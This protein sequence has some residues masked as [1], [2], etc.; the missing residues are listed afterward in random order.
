MCSKRSARSASLARAAVL[1][2]LLVIPGLAQLIDCIVAEVN[3]Q[4]IT[5]T[6]L[7]I[8]RAF[9]ITLAGSGE[10]SPIPV[11]QILEGA[12]DQKVV[13]GLVRENISVSR[14]E[15]N[16]LLDELK[17]NFDPGE[18]ASKL[19]AFG[20][21]PADLEPYLRE[22][23]MYEKIIG[24][25]FGQSIDVNLQEIERYYDDVYAPAQ[26]AQGK[27]PEPMVQVLNNI[28]ARIRREKTEQQVASWVHS[29]RGQADIRVNSDCLQKIE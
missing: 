18:W 7:R 5:L 28:E 8:L 11:R 17:Q 19:D 29:L 16:G 6:D 4:I 12:I 13:I 2:F 10:E 24:L 3:S 23:R 25:R 27:E 9:S 22:K 21:Q 1:V 26:R 15:V 14:E 20:L